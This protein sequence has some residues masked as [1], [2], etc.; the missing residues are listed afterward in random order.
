LATATVSLLTAPEFA[1]EEWLIDFQACGDAG[2]K[3][4]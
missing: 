4:D 3:G 2:E 1:V